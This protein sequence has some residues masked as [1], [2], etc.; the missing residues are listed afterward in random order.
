MPTGLG[1]GATQLGCDVMSPSLAA[2]IFAMITVADAIA[3]MP[4]PPGTQGIK[5][6]IFV[7]SVTRAAGGPPMSTVG[8]PMMIGS[9]NAGCGTG[10]GTGAAG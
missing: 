6:Q 9:G 1:I 8:A 7:V 10:V 5:V 4:G 3:I 2:G